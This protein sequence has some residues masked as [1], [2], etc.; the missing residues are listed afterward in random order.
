MLQRIRE[1]ATGWIAWVIVAAIS[2]TFIFFGVSRFGRIASERVLAKVN[3]EEITQRE[4]DI[5]FERFQ[6][7][8][9][10]MG[11]FTKKDL[12]NIKGQVLQRL[13]DTKILTKAEKNL[14]FRISQQQLLSMIQSIPQFQ[15]AGV[16]SKDRYIQFLSGLRYT[17]QAFRQEIVNMLLDKQVQQGLVETAFALPQDLNTV[18]K[19][20]DQKRDFS[21]ARIDALRFKNNLAV[22]EDSMRQYYD[23]H[24]SDFMHPEKVAIDYIQLSLNDVEKDIPVDEKALHEYYDDNLSLFTDKSRIKVAHILIQ[25]NPRDDAK[26]EVARKKITELQNQLRAGALF[27]SLAKQYSD[28]RPSAKD[29][30]SLTWFIEGEEMMTSPFE[31]AAFALKRIGDVSGIVQTEYGFHLIKLLDK[32]EAKVHPYEEVYKNVLKHYKKEKAQVRLSD[33]VEEMIN[34]S[35]ENS[36]S[37]LPVSDKLNLPINTTPLFD[38]NTRGTGILSHPEVVTAAFSE[39]VLAQRSNSEVF[40]LDET[41]YVVLRIKTHVAA[42]QKEFGEVKVSIENHLKTEKARNQAI[43]LADSLL[44]K[45]AAGEDPK[46]VVQASNLSWEEK[47]AVVRSNRDIPYQIIQAAFQLPNPS[48]TKDNIPAKQ[49]VLADGDVV[50]V[51]LKAIQE[52][53]IS[54]IAPNQLKGFEENIARSLGE[55]DYGLY[56]N[57]VLKQAKVKKEDS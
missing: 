12:D 7:Q 24:L 35:F 11:D 51:V 56:T 42:K 41:T 39:E 9:Q 37:L 4:V 3:G 19:Y 33:L 20:I 5:V 36:D 29:G 28:D 17:D 23:E 54:S 22:T 57:W 38:K 34:L 1:H 32:Q 25:A 43:K 2:V 31:K 18:I 40:Q 21:V 50:I 27:Q 14:G 49:V 15:E 16:F 45:I 47:K 44:E 48:V 26:L 55:L 52:G 8:Q 30:G 6:R 13:I 53:A 46:K 10:A